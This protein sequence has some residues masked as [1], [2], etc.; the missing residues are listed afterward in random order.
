LDRLLLINPVRSVTAL[1][2]VHNYCSG[3]GLEEPYGVALSF[4]ELDEDSLGQRVGA[5]DGYGGAM[6]LVMVSHVPVSSLPH[7]G[8]LRSLS[9]PNRRGPGLR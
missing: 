2:L 8:F 4:E 6:L 7:R 5:E 3:G 9:C 1:L